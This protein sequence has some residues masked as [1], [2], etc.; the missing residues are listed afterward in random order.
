MKRLVSILAFALVLP[1]QAQ[2]PDEY[3]N[4]KR[5]NIWVQGAPIEFLLL[6]SNDH[7]NLW[8]SIKNFDRYYVSVKG[9]NKMIELVFNS[10]PIDPDRGIIMYTT[11]VIGVPYKNYIVPSNGER[12]VNI[13]LHDY[14]N[15]NGGGWAD[16]EKI[17]VDVK[18]INSNNNGD[19]CAY[20][21]INIT[22]LDPCNDDAYRTAFVI[23]HEFTHSVTYTYHNKFFSEGLAVWNSL[24][25]FGLINKPYYYYKM[26]NRYWTGV[27][28][29]WLFQYSDKS[30]F[31]GMIGS[32]YDWISNY[33]YAGLFI[34][35]ID[36]RIG[37]EN[38]K[39]LAQVCKPEKTCNFD[40]PTYE[41]WY[42]GARGAESFAHGLSI[43]NP[44]FNLSDIVVDFHTVN[45]VNDTTVI[46]NDIA[47]GYRKNLYARDNFMRPS[48]KIIV[49][50]RQ[51]SYH[52]S[53]VNILP[54]SVN[55][56]RYLNTSDLHLSIKTN[57]PE[58]TSLRLFKEK[59][60][61]KELVDISTSLEE[62]TIIGDYGRIT[63]IAVNNDPK[64]DQTNVELEIL[65][66]Q[67][68]GVS[69]ESQEFP[70]PVTLAQNYP[71]PFNSSTTIQYDLSTPKHVR[72]EVFDVTGRSVGLLVDGM[73]PAGTYTVRFDA[74][75]LPS[76]LYVYHLQSGQTALTRKMLL[77]R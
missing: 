26:R 3:A 29:N 2:V 43:L 71:N 35:F 65:A 55:Y 60:N 5:R 51:N 48:P 6:D 45:L 32:N 40:D 76:G 13:L 52:K 20:R 58:I 62:Y 27:T 10:T 28:D 64:I 25:I 63:L 57:N 72:L 22:G 30:L 12:V 16:T 11:D 4:N 47:F 37:T 17:Y 49:D 46:L 69:A 56:I 66:T 70:S 1:V 36:Q 74:E 8:M 75:N 41:N 18:G 67:G 50:L 31:R 73:S 15:R 21:S 61:I 9:L 19:S 77:A 33:N 42:V 44:P 34:N 23:T 7:A 68:Y 39:A 54:G 14:P 59:G 24:M 53:N 38:I